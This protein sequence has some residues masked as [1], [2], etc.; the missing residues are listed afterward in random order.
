MNNFLFKMLSFASVVVL[1]AAAGPQAADPVPGAPPLAVPAPT[2]VPAAPPPS[3]AGSAPAAP[4]A[5]T[6]AALTVASPA[7]RSYSA[8]SYYGERYRDPF[9][10]L[11]GDI[12]TDSQ[13][14]RPPAIASLV[15][16]GIVQD[17]KGRMALLTSGVSSYILRG[18]RLFDG[19]NRAV[20]KISGVI[21]TDSV[22][23]IGADRTVREL[24]TKI[25]L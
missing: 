9:V 11:V 24:R 6:P 3:D 25:N 14:D 22:V 19:R 12:R 10:P 2:S 18:G 4:V 23:L 8:Y 17:T 13:F 20:K 7:A 15:L 21:K 5:A 1:V 16:K